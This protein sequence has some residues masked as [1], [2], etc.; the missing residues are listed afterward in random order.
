MFDPIDETV[1]AKQEYPSIVFL[2]NNS[3]H[4]LSKVMSADETSQVGKITK[5]WMGLMELFT[6]ADNFSVTC[7]SFLQIYC[8]LCELNSPDGRLFW[9]LV[10]HYRA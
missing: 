4:F 5:Q 6:D 10:I 2:T 9:L 7:K 1:I 8:Q 3:V